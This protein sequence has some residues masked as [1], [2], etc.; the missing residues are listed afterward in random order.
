MDMNVEADTGGALVV[1]LQGRLDTV[2][3]DQV[4]T[5]FSAA[6]AAGARDALVDLSQVSF[7]S[8]MGVRLIITAARAQRQS[9]HRMVL[10]GAQPVVQATLETVALDLIVPVVASRAEAQQRL[11]G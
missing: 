3:V 11:G 5:R 2:G 1:A 4:E 10:F 8:S 7:L 9:G 6:V